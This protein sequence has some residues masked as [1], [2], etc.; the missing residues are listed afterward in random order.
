M[1]VVSLIVQCIVRTHNTL[2][3]YQWSSRH[4]PAVSPA[5]MHSFFYCSNCQLNCHHGFIIMDLSV[6]QQLYN[7]ILLGQRFE[8][9][10]FLSCYKIQKE[11]NNVK[12]WT[13]LHSFSLVFA[14]K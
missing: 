11:I 2:L 3:Q 12:G 1:R 10:A 8:T 5:C 7:P 6:F 4:S 9:D 13:D 14:I